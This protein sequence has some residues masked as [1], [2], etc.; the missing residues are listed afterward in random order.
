MNDLGIQLEL[1]SVDLDN[2]RSDPVLTNKISSMYGLWL[3]KKAVIASRKQ[4]LTAYKVNM[5]DKIKLLMT[6]NSI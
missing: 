5:L 1:D 2:I 6:M 3:N 4:S